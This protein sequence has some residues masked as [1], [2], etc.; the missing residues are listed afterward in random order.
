[1]VIAHR[2]GKVFKS[3]PDLVTH[4]PT[5]AG[6]DFND[7]K[8]WFRNRGQLAKNIELLLRT[9]DGDTLWK[10][11][12]PGEGTDLSVRFP[13]DFDK[14]S[15]MSVRKGTYLSEVRVD[16]ERW[17]VDAFEVTVPRE[18]EP[19][20]M[21]VQAP[22]VV[23]SGRTFSVKVVARNRG[24]ESDYG[25]ITVSSPDPAGLKLVAAN[26]GKIYGPGSTVLSVTSDKIRTKVPMAERWINLWGENKSYDMEVRIQAGR[27]GTYP[28]YVRCA[29]RGVNV[30]SSVVLMDPDRADTADQQGFPVQVYQITVR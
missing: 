16:G 19:R 1:L 22:S 20:I 13:Q 7:I 8:F 14:G 23:E 10:A 18:A 11:Q 9:P 6:N 17:C 21:E 26:P 24:A 4:L 27:A 30:K 28:L 25:G 5:F 29:L 2:S 3:I 15:S 12:L